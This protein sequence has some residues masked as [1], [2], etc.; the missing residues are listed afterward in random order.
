MILRLPL[1]FIVPITMS[2]PAPA[3]ALR[4]STL[5][6]AALSR[7]STTSAI[8]I[9]PSTLRLP[10]SISTISLR[11]SITAGCAFSAAA[12]SLASGAAWA[13]VAAPRAKVQAS[14]MERSE[15]M[16]EEG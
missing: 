4:R 16:S 10:D 3:V 7:P 1:P 15:K 13:A 9:S 8:F 11:F 12:S 14:A 6:P 5:K 2:A